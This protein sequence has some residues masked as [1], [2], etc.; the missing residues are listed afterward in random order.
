[1]WNVSVECWNFCNFCEGLWTFSTHLLSVPC[2]KDDLR[3]ARAFHAYEKGIDFEKYRY[4]TKILQIS[5]GSLEI[6]E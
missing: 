3:P 6:K 1:M 5:L 4:F 2:F